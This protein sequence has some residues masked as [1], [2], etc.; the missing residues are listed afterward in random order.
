V[1]GFE[2]D[3]AE[4]RLAAGRIRALADSLIELPSV[5]YTVATGEVGSAELTAALDAFHE[6][7][8]RSTRELAELTE[9]TATRLSA[10]ADH[11]ERRDE[12]SA[13]TIT[14]IAR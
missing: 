3:V 13:G 8:R 2:V 7:S 14:G 12:S 6:S 10:T 9:E 4:L 1:D 5:K 11:Y